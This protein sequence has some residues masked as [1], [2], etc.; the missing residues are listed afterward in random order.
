[1]NQTTASS[2][3]RRQKEDAANE[4]IYAEAENAVDTR[5]SSV[6]I[7]SLSYNPQPKKQEGWLPSTFLTI[8]VASSIE[9]PDR[10]ARAQ[11]A[12]DSNFS[13]SAVGLGQHTVV[14]GNGRRAPSLRSDDSIAGSR[15]TKK[16]MKSP[17]K[18]HEPLAARRT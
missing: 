13:P 3:L 11:R 8:S 1:M 16:M 14:R 9:C 10:G 12:K 6:K 2:G 18:I 7:S 4:F 15:R 17:D 5:E